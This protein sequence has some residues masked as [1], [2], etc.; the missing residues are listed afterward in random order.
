MIRHAGFSS[1]ILGYALLDDF[2]TLGYANKGAFVTPADIVALAYATF[3]DF[4]TLCYANYVAFVT[5]GDLTT[6]GYA[7]FDDLS[8]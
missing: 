1:F 7:M 4:V 6:L 3:D 2:I 5:S 8:R